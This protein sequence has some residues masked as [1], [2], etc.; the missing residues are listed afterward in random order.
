MKLPFSEKFLGFSMGFLVFLFA[1]CSQNQP[2]SGQSDGGGKI[3]AEYCA[4]CH[5]G[6]VVGWIS[7]AP[8]TG[9]A[10]EWKPY[11]SKGLDKMTASAIKGPGNMD[12]KGGCDQCSEEQIRSA[13]E[14]I[15]EKTL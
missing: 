11:F 2:V 7:G 14:Y 8:Q 3:Y 1:A 9:E 13:I 12:P 4:G 6:G 5:D 15:Q 10:S